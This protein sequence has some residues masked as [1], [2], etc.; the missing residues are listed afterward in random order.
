[1]FADAHVHIGNV[2][3]GDFDF[4]S[5]MFNLLADKSYDAAL[6]KMEELGTPAIIHSG[7]PQY[8][9][10]ISSDPDSADSKEWLE[11]LLNRID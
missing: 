7:D 5:K 9:W 3:A 1:M 10:D 2:K 8:F 4:P 6:S 11:E